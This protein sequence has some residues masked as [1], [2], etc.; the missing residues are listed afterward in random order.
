MTDPD[1]R[2]PGQGFGIPQ[3]HRNAGGGFRQARA[4]S[5]RIHGTIRRAADNDAH[6]PPTACSASWAKRRSGPV[7]R[8][9]V[10]AFLE[11]TGIR[12]RRLG[13]DALGDPSFVEKLWEGWSARL[14]TVERV[15]AW[16]VDTA[17]PS[18]RATIAS[19]LGDG[20]RTTF[21]DAASTAVQD[22][23]RRA[24]T[25]PVSVAEQAAG[26]LPPEHRHQVFLTTAEA[27]QLLRFTARKLERFQGGP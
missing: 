13:V 9:E 16:M 22:E 14:N 23:S 4:Q 18:E 6:G 19:L 8:R 25:S 17:T 3:A 10:E 1:G 5:T 24:M 2:H 11:V 26:K 7:F 21:V 12:A 20:G 15:R 27:A